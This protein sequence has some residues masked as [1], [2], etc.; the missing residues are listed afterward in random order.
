MGYERRGQLEIGL[1]DPGLGG[2]TEPDGDAGGVDEGVGHAAV[3]FDFLGGLGEE[4]GRSLKARL[5]E[6]AEDGVGGRVDLPVADLRVLLAEV[7][8]GDRQVPVLNPLGFQ[9]LVHGGCS[10]RSSARRG[11]ARRL[12][13][14]RARPSCAAF[15]RHGGAAGPR[16]RQPWLGDGCGRCHVGSAR[17]SLA[18][19]RRACCGQQRAHRAVGMG[20]RLSPR[21]EVF[22]A[23]PAGSGSRPKV[24]FGELCY[25]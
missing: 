12:G 6:V 7:L 1:G 9:S 4:G 15:R 24:G 8:G 3:L 16:A 14:G 13:Q 21:A 20:R 19:R 5:G 10:W 2:V 25:S 17:S 18:L 22:G 11:G 23:G